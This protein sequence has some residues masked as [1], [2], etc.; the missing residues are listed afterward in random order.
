MQTQ[1]L[2]ARLRALRVL[3][4]DDNHYRRTIVRGMLAFMGIRRSY[5]AANAAEAFDAIQKNAP[6][7]VIIEWE[8][9]GSGVELARMIRSSARRPTPDVP[10]IM[11]SDQG[12]RER[13][14]EAAE[15]GVREFL[16][17]PMS[18]KTLHDR[19]AGIVNQPRPE[20]RSG[21]VP[22]LEVH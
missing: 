3:V 17:R 13:A 1:V 8:L 16:L 12:Y 21:P 19:I 2:E 10:I 15:A 14:L 18:P 6:H 5:Q 20:R 4:V 7:L 22:R 9:P 11:L